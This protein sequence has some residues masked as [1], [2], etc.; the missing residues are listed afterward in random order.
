MT[1]GEIVGIAVGVAGLGIAAF[2]ILRRPPGNQSAYGQPVPQ[3]RM[4]A[5]PS[6]SPVV[7]DIGRT[8]SDVA[9]GVTSVVHLFE[10]LFG[11]M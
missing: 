7:N 2:A 10:G 1:T 4:S 5:P 6:P 8:V 9:Q 3:V 11:G